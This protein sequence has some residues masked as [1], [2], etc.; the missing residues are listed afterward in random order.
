[1]N[2]YYDFEMDFFFKCSLYVHN[3]DVKLNIIKSVFEQMSSCSVYHKC[4]LVRYDASL[5]V[6][7]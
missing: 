6:I 3:R 2:E 5:C 4:H 7:H 1:M